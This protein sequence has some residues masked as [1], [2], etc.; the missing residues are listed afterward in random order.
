MARMLLYVWIALGLGFVASVGGIAYAATHALRGWRTF[1][2]VSS[3]VTEALA[4]VGAAATATA[5]HAAAVSERSA[6]V[7]AAT[8][9]LQESLAELAT[10][11]QAADRTRA[12]IRLV[13]GLV[14]HK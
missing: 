12:S 10:L 8:A 4:T 9:R 6:D 14:P 7:A 1:R 11:R 3:S 13:T 5:E 2:A